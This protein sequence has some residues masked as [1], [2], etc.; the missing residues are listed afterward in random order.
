MALSLIRVPVVTLKRKVALLLVRVHT[1]TYPHTHTYTHTHTQRLCLY[2]ESE[3]PSVVD[4]NSHLRQTRGRNHGPVAGKSS[5]RQTQKKVYIV[6]GKGWHT[7]THTHT[8]TP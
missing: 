1:P 3:V 6:T 4:S 2:A 7:H 5:S 8:H